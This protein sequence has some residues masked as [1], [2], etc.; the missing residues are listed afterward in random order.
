VD[1]KKN[2]TC[3]LVIM[4]VILWSRYEFFETYKWSE[5]MSGQE[6]PRLKRSM[7]P[8]RDIFGQFYD[9][10]KAVTY[11]SSRVICYGSVS[12]GIAHL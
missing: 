10:A 11:Q 3:K 1:K 2:S 4:L 9:R 7:E 5:L 8:K 12:N 6:K